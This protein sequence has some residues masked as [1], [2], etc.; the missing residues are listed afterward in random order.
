V[1]YLL[2]VAVGTRGIE[3]ALERELSRIERTILRS[4]GY[5]N[6][7]FVGACQPDSTK[8]EARKALGAHHLFHRLGETFHPGSS[9]P[10]IR[11]I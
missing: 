10:R 6:Q 2:D 9:R 3:L 8:G 5:K 1:T 11:P 4:N 7:R